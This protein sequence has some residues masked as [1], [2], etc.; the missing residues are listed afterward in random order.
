MFNSLSF[1]CS[2]ETYNILISDIDDLLSYANNVKFKPIILVVGSIF[3]EVIC[4]KL[5]C[6]DL[7][8]DDTWFKYN[9]K[10]KKLVRLFEDKRVKFYKQ[11]EK[12]FGKIGHDKSRKIDIYYDPDEF[13]LAVRCIDSNRKSR[14]NEISSA[15]GYPICSLK[16]KDTCDLSDIFGQVIN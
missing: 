11:C 10:Q 3:V 9:K 7:D 12:N 2:D 5:V 6:K 14:G 15:D 8:T 4:A 16:F 13:Y 1:L